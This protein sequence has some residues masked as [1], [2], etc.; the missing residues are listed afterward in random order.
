MSRDA[1]PPLRRTSIGDETRRSGEQTRPEGTPADDASAEATGQVSE[2]VAASSMLRRIATYS[3]GTAVPALL[4]LVTSMIFT[5]IFRPEEY[6]HYSLFLLAVT[7]IRLLFTTWLNQGM[8]KFLPAE[9]TTDGRRRARETVFLCT[10]VVFI[11]ESVFGIVAVAVARLLLPPLDQQFLLPVLLFLVVTSLFEVLTMVFPLEAR[12]SE[13]VSYRLMD[14]VITLGLRLLLV[15]GLVGMDITL[16]FWS[17]V[18]SNGVLLP[19]IWVRAGLPSPLRLLDRARSA[20]TRRRALAFF[21]FGLPMTFWFFSSMLLDIGDRYV[22][23]FL[24]GAAPVGIYDANYRL[25]AGLGMVMVVPI[26]ITVHPYVM[27]L[28]GNTDDERIGRVL[29]KVV[30]NLTLVGL[31]C[32]G[33]MF[34]VHSD[35]ARVLLGPEFREGSVIMPLVLAGVFAFNVGMFT[36]KPF[37]I[38]GRTRTM[39]VFGFVSAALNVVLCF[40]LIPLMGYVGAAWAT[41][42]AYSFYTVSVGV[43]ARRVIPWRVNVRRTVGQAALV[44]GGVSVIYGLRLAWSGLPYIWDLVLTGIACSALAG[45]ALLKLMRQPVSAA[46]DVA[47]PVEH[48]R[49]R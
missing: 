40:V 48:A 37:E 18:L 23:N 21:A 1:R 5:R 47:A 20:D 46:T 22:I 19:V 13:Y 15:S 43:L 36:H 34:I 49:E 31:L 24:K 16:M 14:S 42:L 26:S 32:T 38:V 27:S 7:P 28:S 29:G 35:I 10:G 44:V 3:P 6:G 12:A 45:V 11:A 39:V 33:L 25:V 17:V 4:T 41:F 8:G 30:E 2:G 9:Q